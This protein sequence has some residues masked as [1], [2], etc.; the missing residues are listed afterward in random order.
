V[1]ESLAAL[2]EEIE[3][4][5]ER[6]APNAG[7]QSVRTDAALSERELVGQDLDAGAS[8]GA[9]GI[10]ARSL[11][12]G[13]DAVLDQEERHRVPLPGEARREVVVVGDVRGLEGITRLDEEVLARADGSD[14]STVLAEETAD[15]QPLVA[16]T[17]SP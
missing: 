7:G 12:G 17:A 3:D 6:R 10:G 9:D 5:I 15:C 16:W 1:P 11:P 13:K 8:D 14:E 4:A 2:A